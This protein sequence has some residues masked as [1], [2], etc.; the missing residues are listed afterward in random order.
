MLR[1]SYGRLARLAGDGGLLPPYRM[2]FELTYRCNQR[3]SHCFQRRIADDEGRR[4]PAGELPAHEWIGLAQ[5]VPAFTLITLTGGEPLAHPEFFRIL[6]GV[7]AIRRVNLLSNALL[8]DDRLIDLCL[9][10]HTLLIGSALMGDREIHDRITCV[11]G[12]YD[13]SIQRLDALQRAKRKVGRRYPLLDIKMTVTAENFGCVETIISQAVKLD[14]DFVTFSLEYDNPVKMNPFL[15]QTLDDP[16]YEKVH[17]FGPLEDRGLRA[18]F[19]KLFSSLVRRGSAGRTRFRFYPA[20]RDPELTEDYFLNAER[21]YGKML[22]C[23]DPWGCLIITP[24]GRV[25]PC[26]SYEVGSVID[27]SL[28][29]VWRSERFARFRALIRERGTLP[30]C[31]GCCYVDPDLSAF[32]PSAGR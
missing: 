28:K 25:Y 10:T 2:Q 31:W 24:Q 21:Y 30:A 27:S 32:D 5:Q 17:Y 15:T 23:F 13:A 11:P 22:P 19:A 1:R 16:S 12:S 20:F 26:L 8:L 29:Q 4:L 14:A 18:E 7:G 9:R 3:C 6:E